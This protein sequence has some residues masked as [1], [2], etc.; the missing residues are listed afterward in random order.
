MV[1]E[2]EC[3]H[4][5][6]YIVRPT[7]SLPSKDALL[8]VFSYDPASGKLFRRRSRQGGANLVEV[9]T[10]QKSTPYRHVAFRNRNYLLHRLVGVI[11]HGT[12]PAGG[13]DHID[14]DPL[15]NRPE[16]LRLATSGQN[17]H[18]RRLSQRNK[19]GVK[20]VIWVERHKRWRGLVVHKAHQHFVGN[21]QSSGLP[22]L[23]SSSRDRSFTATSL[24]MN[25]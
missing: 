5:A 16:N 14:G 25:S 1:R 12:P 10:A 11:I 23:L 3:P 6:R 7:K 15:N 2:V 17:N 21:L 22:K 4:L 24:G 9:A 13:I 20:G 8:E 19:S 18:N